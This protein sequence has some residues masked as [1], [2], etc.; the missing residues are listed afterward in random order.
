MF[1]CYVIEHRIYY[2]GGNVAIVSILA[3]HLLVILVLNLILMLILP[4]AFFLYMFVLC[5]FAHKLVFNFSELTNNPHRDRFSI[6]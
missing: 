2:S 1:S 3:L 6:Q 4:P 5:D